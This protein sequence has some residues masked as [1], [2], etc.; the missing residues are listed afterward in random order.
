MRE[1]DPELDIFKQPS[2]PGFQKTMDSEMKRLR[3][4]GKGYTIKRAEPITLDEE[5]S[6]WKQ[7][8]IGE[9]S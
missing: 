5:N 2:F 8:I 4:C 6:L 1:I 3:A 9:H 7:K